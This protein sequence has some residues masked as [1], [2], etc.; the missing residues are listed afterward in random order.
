MADSGPDTRLLMVLPQAGTPALG[1]RAA[2]AALGGSCPS[3]QVLT[4]HA[5]GDWGSS[6]VGCDLGWVL[7]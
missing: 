3:A 6:G 5:F 1:H 4:Q 7:S 2:L